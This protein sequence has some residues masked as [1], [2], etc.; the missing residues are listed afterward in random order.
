MEINQIELK[1]NIPH[2]GTAVGG[3]FAHYF[4]NVEDAT[5]MLTIM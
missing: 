2:I 3:S 5:K 4:I 1:P